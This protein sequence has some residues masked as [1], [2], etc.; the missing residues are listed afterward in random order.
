VWSSAGGYAPCAGGHVTCGGSGGGYAACAGGA[1]G[2]GGHGTCDAGARVCG[3][4]E[5]CVPKV[6]DAMLYVC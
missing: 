5:T 4:L 2:G 3:R 6:G 1:R